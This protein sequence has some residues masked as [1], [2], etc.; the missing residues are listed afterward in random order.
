MS[1]IGKRPIAIPAGVEVKVN[2]NEVAV[3]GPKGSLVRTFSSAVKI[4]VGANGIE[5]S[6]ARNSN[7]IRPMWGT[8]ASHINNM[9]EGVVS[10]YSKKLILEG[11][12][13]KADV[14]GKE[15]SVMAGFTHPV[16]KTIPDGVTVTSE[17]GVISISGIDKEV[18]TQFAASIRSI[19]KAEPYLGKGFRYDDEVIRRKQGKKAV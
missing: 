18:V 4:A 6:L 8:V 12:G 16:K 9:I 11:V 13:H 2:G 14:K 10:G 7:D 3:K 17:K 5:V 15:V 1:R 19:K